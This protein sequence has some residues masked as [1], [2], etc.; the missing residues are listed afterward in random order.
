[1]MQVMRLD[2]NAEA[3]SGSK[4]RAFIVGADYFNSMDVSNDGTKV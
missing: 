3:G 4:V 1:M 2:V